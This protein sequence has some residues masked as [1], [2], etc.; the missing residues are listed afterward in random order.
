MGGGLET[1]D[2]FRLRLELYSFLVLWLGLR[3]FFEKDLC[4]I[5]YRGLVD[6]VSGNLF[7]CRKNSWPPEEYISRNTLQLVS[8]YVAC[9]F[10]FVKNEF[11]IFIRL[12]LVAE[13]L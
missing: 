8:F 6:M 4:Y 3:K 11:L 7:H 2:G 1:L 5:Y 12:N 10:F 9:I 13:K